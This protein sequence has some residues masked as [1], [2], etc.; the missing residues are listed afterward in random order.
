M[1][2]KKPPRP[3]PEQ[4]AD[5]FRTGAVSPTL[6]P[7][8]PDPVL[9]PSATPQSPSATPA[10]PDIPAPDAFLTGAESPPAPPPNTA[11]WAPDALLLD[12][13]KLH[14]IIGRG[15]MGEVWHATDITTSQEVAL[16]RLSL[17]HHPEAHQ[18]LARE[19]QL[20]QTIA[21]PCVVKVLDFEPQAHFFAMELLQGQTLRQRLEQQERLS[22]LDTTRILAQICDALASAHDSGLVHRD[23]KPANI[24][25][26]DE[27]YG[28]VKILDFGIALAS[29]A[30]RLTAQSAR[31]GTAYYMAPE[32][33]Q[34]SETID[35]TADIFSCGII[36]YEMLVGKIP[37][38][39]ARPLPEQFRRL[40][41]QT[42]LPSHEIPPELQ[43]TTFALLERFDQC[44]QKAV[45]EDPQHRCSLQTLANLC[46]EAQSTLVEAFA[47]AT[48]TR[49][50][51]ILD[52]IEANKPPA[53]IQEAIQ[54]TLTHFPTRKGLR[55]L[56]DAWR[57]LSDTDTPP[58]QTQVADLLRQLLTQSQQD[59]PFFARVLHKRRYAL[60][61]LHTFH[62]KG[63]SLSHLC[64]EDDQSSFA[65]TNH[66]GH[67]DIW[68]LSHGGLR[69]T[70]EQ[71]HPTTALA[72]RPQSPHLLSAHARTL[73]LWNITT[74][75]QHGEELR[76]HSVDHTAPIHALSYA[77]DGQ[78]F[79]SGD[80]DGH[81][82]LWSTETHTITHTLEGHTSPIQAL[83]YAPP[84]RLL[85][86]GDEKGEIRVWDLRTHTLYHTFKGHTDAIA[87][88]AF[89]PDAET[90][91]SASHD[92]IVQLWAIH[93]ATLRHTLHGHQDA[94]NDLA[95]LHDANALCT[96]S[97]D[98]RA[99]LW[100]AQSGQLQR[101]LAQH[102][103]PIPSLATHPQG[104]LLYTRALSQGSSIELWGPPHRKRH[105]M[106]PNQPPPPTL[107]DLPDLPLPD[108]P[109]QLPD[110]TS[111]RTTPRRLAKSLPLALGLALI[112]LAIGLITVGRNPNSPSKL[113]Q[114]LQHNNPSKRLQAI[115]FLDKHHDSAQVLL[116]PLQRTCQDLDWEV[117]LAS[118]KLLGELGP[119]AEAATNT[120]K[121]LLQHPDRLTE[122]LATW[123]LGRIASSDAIEALQRHFVLRIKQHRIRVPI[124]DWRNIQYSNYRRKPGWRARLRRRWKPN[125]RTGQT[126]RRQQHYRAIVGPHP[127]QEALLLLGPRIVPHLTPLLL[128][129]NKAVRRA[130]IRLLGH[131]R[132]KAAEAVNALVER[133]RDP[134]TRLRRE[135][136]YAL[137]AIGPKA[138][139]AI[140]TMRDLARTNP[141]LRKLL[142]NAAHQ[143]D[144]D[145]SGF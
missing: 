37:M 89:S 63:S 141:R 123:S 46:K 31:I 80:A 88:L 53:H 29:N 62:S 132:D 47:Q 60:A 118:I 76:L 81:I 26:C 95:F 112:I 42:R 34:G 96:A 107:H 15:G 49:I 79:A 82:H 101:T 6:I 97:K 91:A 119:R 98:G 70:L 93:T 2:D 36:L 23:L 128:D 55:L 43:D 145:A 35:A 24:F 1:S 130:T 120:L 65:C 66:A 13:Y 106:N 39:R 100:D 19:V 109:T 137:A 4:V 27:P 110:T 138:Q 126:Y 78:S 8:I 136:I 84:G 139:S 3:I 41:E 135:A 21:H 75:R 73:H 9:P 11:L 90:L 5:H 64:I 68:A 103:T 40:Q 28:H 102:D 74:A 25:L 51:Q 48:G 38:G 30:T 127:L 121:A 58:T 12:R 33:L 94:V 85:A 10:T 133:L 113:R 99:L 72:F 83:A 77:P 54:R 134:N 116:K 56:S 20:L 108:V 32:Q 22:L 16:K 105:W 67:I 122:Q 131:M 86:S 61:H 129:D 14:R 52:D 59:D 7:D 115:K 71:E 50:L 87:S 104:W 18:R 111:A 117:R 17:L 69:Y 124:P 125:K 143:I 92:N 140:P 44:F 144:P 45:D 142:R 57:K 114:F